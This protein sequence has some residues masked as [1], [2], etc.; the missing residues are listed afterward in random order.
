M[1]PD[2]VFVQEMRDKKSAT[3]AFNLMISG[4]PV[5]TTTH[6]TSAPGI[7]ERLIELGVPLYNIVSDKAVSLLMS[8]ALVKKVCPHCASTLSSLKDSDPLMHDI[9]HDKASKKG[10][11]L[12][13]DMLIRNKSGCNKCEKTGVYGRKLV[14]EHIDLD[15]ND[16]GF[17]ERKAFTEWRQ[18]L[19]GTSY[20]PIERQC[21]TLAL[22]HEMCTQDMLEYF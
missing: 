13:P 2:A 16:K 11:T 21:F 12:S 7:I 4:I 20:N 6:A 17:I 9:L 10:L 14:I 8:Q 5:L 15:E 1:H 3:F 22:Q 19:S 18:Y